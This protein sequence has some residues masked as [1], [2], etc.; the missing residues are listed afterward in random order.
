[1]NEWTLHGTLQFISHTQYC[2]SVLE[3]QPVGADERSVELIV[4]IKKHVPVVC[5][6]TTGYFILQHVVRAG[7]IKGGFKLLV[8]KNKLT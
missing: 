1:M 2:P 5:T 6:D 8:L 7:I 4:N 3:N